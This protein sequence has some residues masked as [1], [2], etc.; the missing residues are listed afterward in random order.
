MEINGKEYE[1]VHS[2]TGDLDCKDCCF[3]FSFDCST[4]PMLHCSRHSVW[5]EVKPEKVTPEGIIKTLKE[6]GLDYDQ[7]LEVIRLVKEKIRD[8]NKPIND[9]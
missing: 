4:L 5:R 3:D 7:M 8:N 6:A 1:L 2:D 9:R